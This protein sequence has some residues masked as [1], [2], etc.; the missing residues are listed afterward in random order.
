MYMLL[1]ITF[2]TLFLFYDCLWFVHGYCSSQVLTTT[3]RHYT[4]QYIV[5][6]YVTHP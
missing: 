6:M 5:E 1:Y 2:P 4:T 3:D